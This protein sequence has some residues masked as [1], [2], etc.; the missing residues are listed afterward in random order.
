MAQRGDSGSR[1][2]SGDDGYDW[3]Y[4][5]KGGASGGASGSG[6]SHDDA[7]AT[8]VI[9]AGAGTGRSAGGGSDQGPPP[10]IAP[11]PGRERTARRTKE[12]PA[13]AAARSKRRRGPLWW[14][15][16]MLLAWLV[17]LIAVPLWAYSTVSK[18]DAEPNGERPEDEGG[19]N[20][21]V[22]GSDE[23]PGLAGRRTVSPTRTTPADGSMP[24]TSADSS[25]TQ[26]RVPDRP[27]GCPARGGI[28]CR[29]SEVAG[30]ADG[31]SQGWEMRQ[32]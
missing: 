8:Q 28:S 12:K 9:P 4:S 16:W 1:G 25:P 7:E 20:Y 15:K 21:L 11:E 32:R 5:G 23:R 24:P 14:L 29:R 30:Y 19:K 31:S 17:F 2:G 3:L 6:G 10:S 27:A 13:R 26:V 22:V 18:V